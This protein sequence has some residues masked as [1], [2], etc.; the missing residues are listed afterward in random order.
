VNPKRFA[1]YAVFL[2][3]CA[4]SPAR[5]SS[6]QAQTNLQ[7][8]VA[9][10]AEREPAWLALLYYRPQRDGSMRSESD[11]PAFFLAPTGRYSPRDELSAGLKAMQT[12]PGQRD[13]A[14]RFP[15]RYEWLRSRFDLSDIASATEQCPQLAQWYA[16]FPGQRISINFA[17]S[18]LENPS[19]TFGHTFLKIFLHSNDELL[20]PTINYAARS[21]PDIGELEFVKKG[22]FGGFPGAVDELPFYRRLRTYSENEGRDIH[23]YELALSP[24]E[25]RQLL[26]HTWEIRDGVFDYYFLHENCAY[27]TLALLDVVRPDAGLLLDF[28]VVTVP[29]DTI[30]ALREHGL[31]RNVTVWPAF[32]KRVRYHEQQVSPDEAR[33]AQQLARGEIQPVHLDPLAPARRAAVLQLAFEYASVLIDRDAG[34]R[35]TRKNILGAI[36]ES[37][38]A[39]DDPA[40]LAGLSGFVT[41][42]DGHDGGLFAA[43]MVRH[44]GENGLSLAYAAFQ[45]KLTDP[46]SG[47]EPHAEITLLNPEIWLIREAGNGR[48]AR[49][50]A[51]RA[52]LHGIDWLVAQSTIP[53]SALFS[54]RSWR[55]QLSTRSEPFEDGDHLV[56]DVAY[57]SGKAWA[58]GRGTVLAIL[59]GARLEAGRVL[60]DSVGASAVVTA[61][62]TRQ[63][64]HWSAQLELNAEK[65]IAG[66]A[67]LRDS[68]RVASEVSLARD[69]SLAMSA[70]QSWSPRRER[71]LTIGLKWRQRAP[72]W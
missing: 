1:G 66:S 24:A 41:P 45:H 18:Y 52:R 43:G 13:Y 67:L 55:L 7:G 39:L 14:C 8:A 9:A 61:L 69:L 5:A 59:P 31:I 4:W 32:P 29:V 37:R 21:D 23:E 36:T 12:P 65:F 26:L 56:S 15:A 51:Q 38:L 28:P 63:S 54:P 19:S 64:R 71:T 11:R 17:S 44:A 30:R 27:R 25:I 3:I 2:L 40:P 33:L 46:L 70:S 34:E 16:R 35:T 68:A 62:L 22:L 42:E 72:G 50:G 20:S 60:D 58:L 49:G 47:Y 57:H 48:G 53:S 10:Q 6:G